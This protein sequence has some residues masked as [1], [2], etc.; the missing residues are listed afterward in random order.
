MSN[1]GRT[2]K[3][4]SRSELD[5]LKQSYLFD[6]VENPSYGEIADSI[7]ITDSVIF[8]HYTGYRFSDDDFW[9]NQTS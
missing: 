1:I 6:T 8:E 2:V 5:E 4:L 3:E 9:C 7:N